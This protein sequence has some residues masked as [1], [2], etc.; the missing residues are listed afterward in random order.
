MNKRP[1]IWL[2]AG[3]SE[4]R[5][6]I[7]A[8]AES[9]I[10]IIVSVATDYGATLIEPQ[11]NVEVRVARMDFS[12]M[13]AFIEEN[14]PDYVV[15]A[16]HPYAVIVTDT[17]KQACDATNCRY[18]RLLRP[19]SEVEGCIEVGSYSEAVDLLHNVEGNIFLTTGSKTLALFA[20]LP[21]YRERVALRILPMQDSLES[22]LKL[23]FQPANIICMQGPFSQELNTA[24]FRHAKAKYVVTKDSGRV[25]GF[26]E[27]KKA[28]AEAGA[29]LIVIKR[30]PEQGGND[31][32]RVLAEIKNLCSNKQSS[33]EEEG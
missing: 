27:K 7:K 9:Q 18:L 24:M 32:E 16:T 23:G 22:A 13:K 15:D 4:G 12:A 5:T 2:I 33:A 31:Y 19:T 26:S 6:L 29:E 28:A 25:G 10:N 14:R 17:L 30:T 1:L 3:T 11:Q 8:L 20:A 21:N